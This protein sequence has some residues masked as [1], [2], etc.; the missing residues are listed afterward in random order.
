ML[1]IHSGAYIA[2]VLITLLN[3]PL[4]LSK[5]SP[6]WS[7]GATLLS[8]LAEYIARCKFSA[9]EE[10]KGNKLTA[11]RSNIRRRILRSS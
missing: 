4:E 6:A 7:E 9:Q 8:G 3:L 2:A 10:R 5:D 11:R 1:I